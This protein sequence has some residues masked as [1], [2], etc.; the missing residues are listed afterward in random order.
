M[1]DLRRVPDDHF[2]DLYNCFFRDTGLGFNKLWSK[3][4]R[5]SGKPIKADTMF[6]DKF[7]CI[8]SGFYQ[9]LRQAPCKRAIGARI[10]WNKNVRSF[11]GR[12]AAGID[13]NELCAFL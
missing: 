12:G 5:V 8:V 2:T 6:L 13:D 7:P 1:N 9:V 11:G 4:F 3:P 10:N